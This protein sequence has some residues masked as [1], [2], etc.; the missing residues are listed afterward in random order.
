MAADPLQ[1]QEPV[2][3]PVFRRVAQSC[4]FLLLGR[5]LRDGNEAVASSHAI[6]PQAGGANLRM[7]ASGIDCQWCVGPA[8]GVGGVDGYFCVIKRVLQIGPDEIFAVTYS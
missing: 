5:K 2:Q 4:L 8:W 3:E 6:A 7:S 1:K